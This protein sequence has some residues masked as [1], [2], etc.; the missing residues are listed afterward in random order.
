MGLLSLGV[1]MAVGYVL[2]TKHG[3][4]GF[5]QARRSASEAWNDPDLQEKIQDTVSSVGDTA[6]KVAQDVAEKTRRA[7]TAAA[8]AVRR[9]G[10]EAAETFE[11]EFHAPETVP[12]SH[13][14]VD[15]D[16][17]LSTEKEGSDWAQEGGAPGDRGGG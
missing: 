6:G 7:A 2:G 14:D 5:E 17:G 1:G 8:E 16:P 10:A 15:S 11:E 9:G 4:E 12:S 13:G 3:K